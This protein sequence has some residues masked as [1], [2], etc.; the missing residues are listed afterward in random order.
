[1]EGNIKVIMFMVKKKGSAYINFEMVRFMKEIGKMG[2]R[3]GKDVLF[4][5][6]VAD[7]KGNG[8]KVRR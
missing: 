2:I 4:C 1:M 5:L 8:H 3:M 7:K 6:M